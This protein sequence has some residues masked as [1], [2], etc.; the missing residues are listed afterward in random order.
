M[1]ALKSDRPGTKAG[2]HSE[3]LSQARALL[4]GERD[5]IDNLIKQLRDRDALF[6]NRL[7]NLELKFSTAAEM[8]FQRRQDPHHGRQGGV[9]GVR[10]RRQAALLDDPHKRF[11]RPELVHDG[12][13]TSFYGVVDCI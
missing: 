11:H 4:A 6:A 2:L 8:P 5:A 10:G 12:T 13:I 9:E 7:N 1:F 3:L